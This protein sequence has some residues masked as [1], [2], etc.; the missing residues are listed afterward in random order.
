[1]EKRVKYSLIFLAKSLRAA[2]FF[3]IYFTSVAEVRWL[4]PK[5]NWAGKK[6]RIFFDGSEKRGEK[7]GRTARKQPGIILTVQMVVR[8]HYADVTCRHKRCRRVVRIDGALIKGWRCYSS[9]RRRDMRLCS[10]SSGSQLRYSML[11]TASVR[12]AS[13]CRQ[14]ARS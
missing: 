3:V 1:M 12:G 5:K 14:R 13:T 2:R 8:L 7:G 4:A 6:V 10:T 11:C 9:R